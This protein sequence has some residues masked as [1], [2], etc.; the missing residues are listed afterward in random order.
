MLKQLTPYVCATTILLTFGSSASA[1]TSLAAIRG[2][3]TDS[4]HALIS[5]ATVSRRIG[6]PASGPP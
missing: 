3:V 5:G 2:L 4:Q 6:L 1:Q